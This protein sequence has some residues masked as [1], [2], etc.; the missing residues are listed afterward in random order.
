MRR[1]TERSLDAIF[2]PDGDAASADAIFEA[3]QL[4]RGARLRELLLRCVRN[5]D[6][7]AARSY[8]H[9]NGFA[10]LVLL[11]GDRRYKVRLHAWGASQRV[12][13]HPRSPLGLRVR[14]LR[15]AYAFEELARTAGRTHRVHRYAAVAADSTFG[16]AAQAWSGVRPTRR[17]RVARGAEYTLPADV[18]HRVAVDRGDTLTL[19]VQ[20]PRV[21]EHTTVLR[22]AEAPARRIPVRR[23]RPDTA[24]QILAEALGAIEPTA[25][26]VVRSA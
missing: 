11:D 4:L 19:V 5:A 17:G 1:L 10:K 21:R 26:E 20:G 3:M 22:R 16:L 15:G 6:A 2:T 12:V 24:R 7:V 18:L 25:H 13:G 23:L 9:A 8:H 14:V